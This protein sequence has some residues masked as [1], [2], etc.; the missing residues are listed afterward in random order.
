MCDCCESEDRNFKLRCGPKASL[1]PMR[2]YQMKKNKVGRRP[3]G[4]LC[5]LCHTELFCLGEPRF[6][7]KHNLFAQSLGLA[8]PNDKW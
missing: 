8:N 6:F 1:Q 2:L 5:P 4:Q 3:K 7:K